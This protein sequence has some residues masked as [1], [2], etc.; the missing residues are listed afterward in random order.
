MTGEKAADHILGKGMLA[1]ANV[2]PWVSP[3]WASSQR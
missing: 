1:P 2:G 3:R